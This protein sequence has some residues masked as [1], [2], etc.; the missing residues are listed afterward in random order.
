MRWRS[1]LVANALGGIAW[2]A[3]FGLAGYEFGNAIKTIGTTLSIVLGAFALVGIA[4]GSL[5]LRRFAGE[6]ERRAERACP[7]LAPSLAEVE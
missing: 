6:I 3:S 1:F 7:D 5:V 2:A 4:A